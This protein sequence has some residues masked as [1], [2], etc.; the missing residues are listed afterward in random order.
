MT[1]GDFFQKFGDVLQ[2]LF[3]GIINTEIST[4]GAIIV[5]IILVILF[6]GAFFFIGDKYWS[7][8]N[9]WVEKIKNPFIKFVVWVI[10]SVVGVSLLLFIFFILPNLHNL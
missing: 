6:I 9:D 5:G 4:I 7:W 10:L 8:L 1:V 3:Q 2:K